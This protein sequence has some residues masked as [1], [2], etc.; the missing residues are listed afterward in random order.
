MIR[1]KKIVIG[2]IACAFAVLILML[3][4]VLIAPKVVDTETVRDKVRSEIKKLAGVEIDFK[5]L[6]LDFFPQP[7]VIFDRVTLSIP[8]AVR[9]RA[10]SVS[11]QL[12]ILPLF[13][14]KLQIA[15]LHLDSAE[16]DYTLA[17]KSATEKTT[18]QPFSFD[19]LAKRLQSLVATLPEFKIPKSVLRAHSAD[20]P[21]S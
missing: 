16:L 9:G 13:L 17:K 19:D 8:P 10:V 15:G 6:V 11:V 2:I 12:K 14:G 20:W 7:H 18:P 5:H 4:V 3:T 21:H 1:R